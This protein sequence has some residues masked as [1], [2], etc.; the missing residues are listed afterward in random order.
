MLG[1]FSE[2][3]PLRYLPIKVTAC[4]RLVVCKLL[5]FNYLLPPRMARLVPRCP[6]LPSRERPKE[7][8]SGS[9]SARTCSEYCRRVRQSLKVW[10]LFMTDALQC[11]N[12]RLSSGVFLD[13]L[14]RR[15]VLLMLFPRLFSRL[16]PMRLPM[17]LPI[18]FPMR[19]PMLSPKLTFPTL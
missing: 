10:R 19:R 13:A 7:A 3:E 8:W 17:R 1:G 12:P 5:V 16:F 9:A 14:E 2:E 6:L 18:R 15:K 4:V 11:R